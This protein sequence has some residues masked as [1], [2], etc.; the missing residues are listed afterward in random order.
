MNILL[1]LCFYGSISLKLFRCVNVF[2]FSLIV[3]FFVSFFLFVA[4]TFSGTIH[5]EKHIPSVR[6]DEFSEIKT[7]N[8]NSAQEKKAQEPQKASSARMPQLQGSP[9][10]LSPITIACSSFE[11][12]SNANVEHTFYLLFIASSTQ[13]CVCEMDLCGALVCSHRLATIF[14]VTGQ[15]PSHCGW[16]LGLFQHWGSYGE[17]CL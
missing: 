11:L 4:G 1:Y 10:I 12:Y 8:Y 13:H 2:S 6:L 17:P 14:R 9:A 7:C 16:V 5:I 15:R 3:S